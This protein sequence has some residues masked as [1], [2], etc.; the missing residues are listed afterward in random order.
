MTDL[1]RGVVISPTFDRDQGML[2]V[3]LDCRD[4]NRLWHRIKAGIPNPG[5][6]L[7]Q[8][9]GTHIAEDPAAGPFG[10]G[11]GLKDGSVFREW[12]SHYWPSGSTPS[13]DQVE[14][15]NPD[16]EYV[17]TLEK[18]TSPT[19]VGGWLDEFITHQNPY[20]RYHYAPDGRAWYRALAPA[21]TLPA[22]PVYAPKRI[23]GDPEDIDGDTLIANITPTWS[24]DAIRRRVW[25]NGKTVDAQK[26]VVNTDAPLDAG[27]EIVDAPGA[28]VEVQ[29]D[30]IGA[31]YLANKYRSF[32]SA[33][34]DLTNPTVNVFRVGQSLLIKDREFSKFV[35][36]DL[37]FMPTIITR[38]DGKIPTA[39]AGITITLDGVE[40]ALIVDWTALSWSEI[41][42]AQVGSARI[43]LWIWDPEA[44]VEIADLARV[45]ITTD[46]TVPITW[47]LA[48]GDVEPS[49]LAAAL[50]IG[51]GPK[52][53]PEPY[54]HFETHYSD[55]DMP[56]GGVGY[57]WLQ[58]CTADGSSERQS[59][60]VAD[61]SIEAWADEDQTVPSDEYTTDDSTGTT[62]GLGQIYPIIRR[63]LTPT[64]PAVKWKLVGEWTG[65]FPA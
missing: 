44:T 4:Y 24:W 30:S 39:Q 57:G 11:S 13:L 6:T 27:E 45:L 22:S 47:T 19:D 55:P 42:F 31:W 62:N 28:L 16:W 32:V 60:V 33:T 23:C 18:F 12:I 1:F 2:H 52:F 37:D 40:P 65:A 3:V 17:F 59:G 7:D 8:P 56:P 29:A 61:I 25:I 51:T 20:T 15:T 46:D 38:A 34:V 54:Y 5:T 63:E 36:H 41:G 9:D 50:D 53:I 48:C 58:L 49:T 35:D 43:E 10:D 26:W 14:E 21:G 64:D